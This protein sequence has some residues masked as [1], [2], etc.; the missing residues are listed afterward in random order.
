MHFIFFLLGMVNL[1]EN[2]GD[3]LLPYG[4]ATTTDWSAESSKSCVFVPFSL[5]YF[6]ALLLLFLRFVWSC[7]Y[8]YVVA[9]VVLCVLLSNRFC[10][11]MYVV[12]GFLYM[13]IQSQ[14]QVLRYYV[15]RICN[16]FFNINSELHI[17]NLDSWM[18]IMIFDT[19][20]LVEQIKLNSSVWS[21]LNCDI[22]I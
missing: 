8:P 10:L 14:T 16:F 6:G 15:L 22:R 18:Y 5:I 12:M 20:T 13:L 21:S 11:H 1:C 3:L 9:V 4:R 17:N 7:M 2:V 19:W